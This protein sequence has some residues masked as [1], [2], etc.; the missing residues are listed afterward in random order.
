[1][2]LCTVVL[3]DSRRV[4]L[5]IGTTLA[6]IEKM[7]YKD[8]DSLIVA[9]NV[10]NEIQELSYKIGAGYNTL[11]PIDLKNKDGVRIYQRSLVFVFSR[12]VREC[13][14]NARSRVEHS[15]SKGLFCQVIKDSPLKKEEVSLIEAKMRE[16]IEKGESF[17]KCN[18]EIAKAKE[19]YKK[20]GLDEKV[21]ILD[22]RLEPTFKTYKL[23][24]YNDYYYGYMLPDVKKLGKFE[25]MYFDGGLIIRHPNQYSN[26]DIPE[27][28]SQK[29]LSGIYREAENWAKITG[30]SYIHNI[31]NL[32]NKGEISNVILTTEALHEKKIIEIADEI[33]KRKSRVI[34]IAGPSSSGKTTFAGRLR[35]QLS[36]FGLKP[37]TVSVD[38]YFVNRE[39]TPIDENGEF[40]FE[41]ID[42]IDRKLFNHHISELLKGNE[43]DLPKFN[44]HLGQREESGKKLKITEDMPLII[45]GIHGLNPALTE[46]IPD[47]YKFKI[48]ISCLTQL[49][50]DAHNRIPTTDS[51]LIRRMVRDAKYR[52]NDALTTLKLWPSVR[53]G[54]EKNIFPFQE[55]ADAMF[56]SATVYELSAL[57]RYVEPLLRDIPY[58]EP[59]LLEAIRL[60]KF[61]AYVVPLKTE[62]PIP[63]TAIVREFIGGNIY[64]DEH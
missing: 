22:Y 31:N 55:T 24:W 33:Y 57:K 4:E 62:K 6:E 36:V 48:Y 14:E 37:V 10:N 2:A 41:S 42:A 3:N 26:G 61:L 15:L 30:V 9:F 47:E 32:I 28:V 27:F 60:L 45:E 50:V 54:E 34:L 17:E 12:A 18:L 8:H 21:S 25:L 19:I 44:F 5:E 51:R 23:G 52:G 16:I 43:I 20:Q 63:N 64:H 49:N 39:K 29:K 53:R 56:N 38:D 59:E 46:E 40:N 13:F 35:V 11:K 1:M 58:D 7:Y